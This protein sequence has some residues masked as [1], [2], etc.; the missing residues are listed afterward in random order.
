[1]V[2]ELFSLNV[3]VGILTSGVRLATSY[4]YAAIGGLLDSASRSKI[5]SR[6][7]APLDLRDAQPRVA[8]AGPRALPQAGCDLAS[9]FAQRVGPLDA[10][11]TM[12]RSQPT[13]T[14]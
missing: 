13:V 8:A 3:I 5:H 6:A 14:P 12:R 4:L 2:S 11:R 1:M 7:V 10:A 9:P